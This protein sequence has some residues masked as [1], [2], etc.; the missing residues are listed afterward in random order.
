MQVLQ[1]GLHISQVVQFIL[2]LTMEKYGFFYTLTLLGW[3]TTVQVVYKVQ[4]SLK[5]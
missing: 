3:R 2:T 5:S 1:K 4:T